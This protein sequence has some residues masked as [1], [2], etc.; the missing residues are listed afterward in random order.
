LREF[1]R[2]NTQIGAISR[3]AGK[4]AALKRKEIKGAKARKRAQALVH[5]RSPMANSQ[6]RPKVP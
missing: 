5:S 3:N 4:F 6:K 1:K 2:K